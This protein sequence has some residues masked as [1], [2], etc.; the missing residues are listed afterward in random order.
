MNTVFK[1]TAAVLVAALLLGAL[2]PV[3]ALAATLS[4]S[5]NGESG[6]ITVNY[7]ETKGSVSRN[8]YGDR[9]PDDLRHGETWSFT[10]SPNDGY[11]VNWT[12]TKHNLDVSVAG[13][14]LIVKCNNSGKPDWLNA[15]ANFVPATHTVTFAAGTHGSLTGQ[16]VYSGL[17]IGDDF[18]DAPAVTVDTGWEFTGWDPIPPDKVQ[19]TQ[20]YTAQYSRITYKIS[21]SVANGT[22]NP[23]DPTVNHG[24]DQEFNYSPVP[25]RLDFDNRY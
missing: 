20:T 16:T 12:Y 23:V 18:P 9:S 1:K 13:N 8:V 19:G 4:Y 6:R 3:S 15:K 5:C 7:D 24:E 17:H 25:Q 14:V 22:I 10:A 11:A 2:M 21:T